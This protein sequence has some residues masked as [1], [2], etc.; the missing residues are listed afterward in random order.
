VVGYEHPKPAS[1]HVL[2]DPRIGP[3]RGVD[4]DDIY[5]SPPPSH[6][7]LVLVALGILGIAV[8]V[9]T[10]WWVSEAGLSDSTS[11][12]A[13]AE[14]PQV[15]G[16]AEADAVA[17]LEAEEFEVETELVLNVTVEPGVVVEQRPRGGSLLDPGEVVSITISLGSG[18]VPVPE[19][20]G[21]IGDQVGAQLEAYG[22]VVG[23]LSSREDMNSLEGEILEQSPAPGEFVIMGSA[24]DLVVSEGPPP[25]VVP[26]VRNL[27]Q[28]EATRILSDLGLRVTPVQTYSAA[29]RGTVVATNPRPEAEADYG[30]EIRVFVSRGA[31]PTTVPPP[32]T[33]PPS[34]P[35]PTPTTPPPTPTPP[36]GGGGGG[37][38]DGGGGPG[39]GGPGGPGQ[40]GTQGQAG[41]S[42]EDPDG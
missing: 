18:F 16:L 3:G 19:V 27:T 37:G 42:G 29:R 34:D 22:L 5:Y 31:A 28:A 15:T 4:D 32:T 36:D 8:V 38:G 9:G 26:D 1:G 33:P 10:G 2:T 24:V 41:P 39:G 25:V 20:T 11:S 40:G 12:D 14:V 6:P 13:R 23:S 30:S 7:L 21:T 17:A 35:T